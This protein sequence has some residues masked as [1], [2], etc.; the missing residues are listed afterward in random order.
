MPMYE[1]RCTACRHEWTQSELISEHG[2]QAP[3]CPECGAQTVER[4]F[5]AFFAKTVRKS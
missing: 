3:T 1:Y 5:S 4:I 2:K